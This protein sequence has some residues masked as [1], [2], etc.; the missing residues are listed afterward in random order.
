MSVGGIPG[1][2]VLCLRLRRGTNVRVGRRSC[3]LPRGCYAGSAL[4]GLRGRVARHLRTREP[5]HWHIDSLLYPVGMYRQKAR[6]LREIATAILERFD[7]E[8]PAGIEELLTLPGVGRKTAN[9]V[10]SFAFHKPAV[11]VD[12]HVHRIANR[13]GI[14]RTAAPDDTEWELRRVLPKRHWIEINPLLVQHGRAVCRPRRPACARCALLRHCGYSQL[15]RER[16]I[17]AG[18]AGCPGHPALGKT[19]EG[20]RKKENGR[21]KREE[22][23]RGKRE[24]GGKRK[25]EEGGKR[26]TDGAER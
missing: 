16:E 23:G 24:E 7:G 8:T 25:R 12:V 19:E 11:C 1:V 15:C 3:R 10:R 20:K 2:Y 21:G 17:L 18:V 13:L 14:V 22:N 26:E 9:L 5:K 6:A 4:G